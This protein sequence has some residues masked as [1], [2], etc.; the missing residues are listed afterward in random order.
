MVLSGGLNG[1]QLSGD[2]NGLQLNGG[3][4]GLEL[5]LYSK[6]FWFKASFELVLVN[7]GV[8]AECS[9]GKCDSS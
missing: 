9:S 8:D 3:S 1:L 5:K 4:N 2:L 7:R 6:A